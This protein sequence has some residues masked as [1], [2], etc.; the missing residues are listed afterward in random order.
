MPFPGKLVGL[1]ILVLSQT[2]TSIACFVLD[3]DPVHAY[4]TQGEEEVERRKK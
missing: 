4:E 2:Q 1:E 3:G